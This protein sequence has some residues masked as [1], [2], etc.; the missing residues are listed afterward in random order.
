M[1]FRITI[2]NNKPVVIRLQ[3]PC[4][5]LILFLI[6]SVSCRQPQEETAFSGEDYHFEQEYAEILE[7]REIFYDLY[8]P[9]EAHRLFNQIDLV[10]DP[11]ILNPLENQF[12]YGSS[13]KNAV[14]L[15]IYGADMSYCHLFGQ[16][17]E[18]I[19]YMSAIYRLA[20]RLGIGESILTRAEETRD[21]SVYHPDSLFDIASD[22]Y[23]SADRQLKESD[24]AGAASLIL[25]GGWIEALYIA[26]S[27][28]DI[29]NPDRTLEEQIL[30]QKYS[31]DRLIALLSNY[32]ND[33]FI[34]KYVLM[35][36][37]LKLYFDSVDILFEQDDLII[38]TTNKTIGSA[39]P[40]FVYTQ[41]KIAEIASLVTLIRNDMIY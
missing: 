24:R 14:N 1:L 33:E 19:N 12:R 9:M 34:A 16:T 37:Q 36:K 17:Q 2:C 35:L 40:T 31:L 27:F 28:Y 29:D 26:C 11:A 21:R 20:D 41:N 23:I 5:L 7:V 38:D 3:S 8:S 6:I 39:R 10:F 4:F 22:I 25:A 32:Q 13:N 18:A 30:T 15:G